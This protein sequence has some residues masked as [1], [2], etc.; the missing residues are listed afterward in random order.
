MVE[1][2]FSTSPPR[3]RAI[4]DPSHRMCLV[5]HSPHPKL[6]I[7]P[8]NRFCTALR[9]I[10]RNNANQIHSMWPKC[11]QKHNNKVGLFG[12]ASKRWIDT[13]NKM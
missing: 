1:T 3:H 2:M 12:L 9:I 6:D 13:M 5:S 8:Y 11:N 10:C 4:M 7:D